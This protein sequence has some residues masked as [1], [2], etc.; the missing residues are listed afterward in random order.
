MIIP[1]SYPLRSESPLYPGT[2]SVAIKS[3]KAIS[4]G[5][6][7]NT[8]MLT[9]SSHAGTHVDVPRHF[10]PAGKTVNDIFQTASS[11]SPAYCIDLPVSGD[12]CIRPEEID[13]LLA[14]KEDAGA[15]L[16]R[17]GAGALRDSMPEA[18]TTEHPWIHA[19]VAPWIR[20]KCPRIRIL[21]IDAISISTP[22]HRQEGRESHRAFLCDDNPILL[23][24]DADLSSLHSDTR[25]L[26]TI[27]PWFI[28]DIDGVPV[29]AFISTETIQS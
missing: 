3:H 16:I 2:P 11:F 6:S 28:G 20:R 23:L 18:Y 29:T 22:A 14:G 9:F 8:S 15:L 4:R 7:S 27:L 21:G 26:L 13:G 12:T 5:D 25:G 24:E 17:T 10:C 1:L 19:R